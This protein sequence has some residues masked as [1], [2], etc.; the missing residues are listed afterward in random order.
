MRDDKYNAKAMRGCRYWLLTALLISHFSF[1][2][3]SV[4]AQDEPEYRLEVGA[5]V[6]M[7]TYL[8]DFNGNLTKEMQPAFA[9]VTKYKM[10]P[11]MALGA[12]LTYGHMKGS[13]KNTKTW[14]PE[15]AEMPYSFN[16]QLIDLSLRYEY[17]FWAYGTGREYYGARR[18]APF[19]ALGLG[20]TYADAHPGTVAA[21]LPLGA[22]VKMKVSER[23]NLT[24]DWTMH[25]TGTDR[26][27]GIRDPYGITSSG[28]LKN[29][30]CYSAFM[31]SLTYDIWEKCKTCNNDR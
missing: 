18:V 4:A 3:C 25:F 31:L 22:G 8:G 10:N 29:T 20:L 16:N 1:L 24:V 9:L 23:L 15:T 5:G 19:I 17:N 13:S 21:S 7:T 30:D 2:I 6:A 27:D 28:L 26:L 12:T 14:Y 11:R